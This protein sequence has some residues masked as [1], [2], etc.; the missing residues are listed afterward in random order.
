MV[1]GGCIVRVVNGVERALGRMRYMLIAYT[2][3]VNCMQNANNKDVSVCVHVLYLHIENSDTIPDQLFRSSALAFCSHWHNC[4]GCMSV[5][6]FVTELSIKY[7]DEQLNKLPKC[8]SLSAK[9]N[10]KR[11]EIK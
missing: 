9:T 1:S 11:I 5:V 6:S 10:S 4:E 7:A 8:L 3:R 2:Q